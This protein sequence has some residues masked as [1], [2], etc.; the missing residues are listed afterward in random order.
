[1]DKVE[2]ARKLLR[3]V[4]MPKAQQADICC[5][6]LLAM[7]DIKPDISWNEAKNDWIRIHDIIRFANTFYGTTYAENSGLKPKRVYKQFGK[8]KNV[9]ADVM[10]NQRFCGRKEIEK[11]RFYQ[12][13]Y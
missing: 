1:M 6:V 12:S 7:A 11:S 5:Y 9:V 10:E 13:R 3:S 8:I 4:G 2:E